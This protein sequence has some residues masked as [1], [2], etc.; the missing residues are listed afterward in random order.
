MARLRR[1]KPAGRGAAAAGI[2]LLAVAVVSCHAGTTTGKGAASTTV[3]SGSSGLAM[4]AHS[5]PGVTIPPT[6]LPS[7]LP[8]T[9]PPVVV[10]ILMYHYVD[11]SPSPAGPYSAGPTA[12]TAQFAAEM[13]YL[14]AS[15]HHPVTI[16]QI[17][18]DMAGQGQLPNKPIALSF[19]DDGLDDYAVAFPILEGHHFVATF[20]VI[21][22]LVGGRVCMNWD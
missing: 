22:G 14:A 8:G 12:P 15:G 18:A 7:L 10:P 5:T 16:E 9:A 3:P 1:K 19:D 2:N 4:G 17:Y 21:T 6:K 13:D 20:F 11:Y